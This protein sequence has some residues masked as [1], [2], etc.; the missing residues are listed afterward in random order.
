MDV[1]VFIFRIVPLIGTPIVVGIAW[2]MWFRSNRAALWRWRAVALLVSLVA[3]SANAVMYCSWV[4]YLT[5]LA[6]ESSNN[7][8]IY[9]VFG[10]IADYLALVGLVG[11]IVGKGRGRTLIAVGA[12]M[13][14]LLWVPFVAF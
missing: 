1:P 8:P 6:D 11:A 4:V 2:W 9:N 10:S 14:F 3:V 12:I 7:W 5:I 13:G